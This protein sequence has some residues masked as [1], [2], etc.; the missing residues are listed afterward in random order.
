MISSLTSDAVSDMILPAMDLFHL[1]FHDSFFITAL[2][3][4]GGKTSVLR[5]CAG[6]AGSRGVSL[7]STTT[8]KLLRTVRGAEAVTGQLHVG[9]SLPEEP[10][11]PLLWVGGETAD[12][13]KWT[14]VPS[15]AL[16]DVLSK[17][18][19]RDGSRPAGEMQAV[20]IEADG[21]AGRP[22]KAPGSGE[23]VIPPQADTVAVL[24]GLSALGRRVS[25]KTVHRLEIFSP[26]TGASAGGVITPELLCSLIVHPGG[27]FKGALPGM[28][29]ILILNQADSHEDLH[30]AEKIIGLVKK[31][32]ERSTGSADIF[33]EIIAVTSFRSSSQNNNPVRSIENI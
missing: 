24:L 25:E 18:R 10:R 4:G 21:S 30:Q 5:Y 31:L 27:S 32:K 9:G 22:V 20:L 14:A 2:V 33:P 23:P 11:W 17:V 12:R 13:R 8:T 16:G 6:E 19:Q 7:L 15:G 26:L 28:R 3:G 29:R 1:L